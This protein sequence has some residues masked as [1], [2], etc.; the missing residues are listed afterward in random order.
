MESL[1]LLFLFLSLLLSAMV[2]A[3]TPSDAPLPTENHIGV[4]FANGFE[5]SPPGLLV[6]RN[7]KLLVCKTTR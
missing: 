7:C 6:D 1:K 2:Q 3:Q 4:T 5:I